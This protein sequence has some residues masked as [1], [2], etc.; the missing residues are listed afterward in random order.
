M[1]NGYL[2]WNILAF[3]PMAMVNSALGQQGGHL[4]SPPLRLANNRPTPMGV[5]NT[6]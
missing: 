3:A 2:V 5:D 4:P 1:E 6:A